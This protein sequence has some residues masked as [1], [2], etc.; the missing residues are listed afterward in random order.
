VGSSVEDGVRM[1][2]VELGIET[3]WIKRRMEALILWVTYITNPNMDCIK[4]EIA[5]FKFG[6]QMSER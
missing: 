4:L 6:D 2:V 3:V 1:W 5:T